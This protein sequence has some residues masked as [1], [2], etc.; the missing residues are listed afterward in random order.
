MHLASTFSEQSLAIVRFL[1]FKGWKYFSVVYEQGQ[2]AEDAFNVIQKSVRAY[3]L[4]ISNTAMISESSDILRLVKHLTFSP[5]AAKVVLVFVSNTYMLRIM[6]AVRQTKTE[7]W[8]LWVG[9]SYWIKYMWSDVLVQGSMAVANDF[10]Y[11][12]GI[13]KALLKLNRNNPNPWFLPMLKQKFSCQ[14]N[15][16]CI[17]SVIQ[18][19]EEGFTN[20]AGMIHDS[21][22]VVVRATNAFLFSH[23]HD[24]RRSSRKWAFD[25][26]ANNRALFVKFIRNVSFDGH[27]GKV[28]FDK[29]GV[30]RKNLY[31]YQVIYDSNTLTHRP[32]KIAEISDR[33]TIL[34]DISDPHSSMKLIDDAQDMCMPRCDRH[35]YHLQKL[36]CCWSCKM[37][38]TNEY[39]N[40]NKTAC[41]SCPKFY[42]PHVHT[43][44]STGQCIRIL[45]DVLLWHRP[46]PAFLITLTIIGLGL[47]LFTLVVYW[48]N[49]ESSVIKSASL[50]IST[51]QLVALFCGFLSVP[52]L[53]SFPTELG[54]FVGVVMVIVSL[55]SMYMTMLL[56]AVRVYRIFLRRK[57]NIKVSYTSSKSQV[58]TFL[59]FAF[60]E[61]SNRVVYI[62]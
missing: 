15:D 33:I 49:S 10:A 40:A 61:V 7:G 39:V 2:Y 60:I 5:E 45:S 24:E 12:P 11:V 14:T 55:T 4:C 18:A 50:E 32:V 52:F 36:A 29:N 38:Q 59:T 46:V 9:T 47:V 43:F 42:W 56:K 51:I 6:D 17:L 1:V 20:Y 21:V 22:Q 35:A 23:C 26:I 25:C 34:R 19:Y 57:G 28:S 8:N 27:T 53:V 58:L 16:A 54:C 30:V 44:N 48:N 41:V 31:L 3:G 37:C 62:N 13:K